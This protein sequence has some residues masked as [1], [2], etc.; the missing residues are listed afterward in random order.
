VVAEN[1]EICTHRP[2]LPT[3]VDF[4][5]SYTEGHNM[6]LMFGRTDDFGVGAAMFT[7]YAKSCLATM[8]TVH[9][10]VGGQPI[11][12]AQQAQ[13]LND[14]LFLGYKGRHRLLLTLIEIDLRS[15]DIQVIN[16][17]GEAPFC[18]SPA[19]GVA[20]LNNADVRRVE[21]VLMHKDFSKAG[22]PVGSQATVTYQPATG[23]LEKGELL[24]VFT[25]NKWRPKDAK[26]TTEGRER[27]KQL[28]AA[29]YSPTPQ[30][31]SLEVKARNPFGDEMS[32]WIVEWR[33]AMIQRPPAP[34]DPLKQA[35]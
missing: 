24:F 29:C 16:A 15:G 35:A 26:E 1:V 27:V 10:R 21:G 33:S 8:R 25:H 9:R 17:G 18:L 22:P 11:T 32:F 28:L 3:C 12:L 31:M 4:W 23:K 6:T 13:M 34:L 14:T 7:A 19:P 30:A 20:A 5:D 2:E